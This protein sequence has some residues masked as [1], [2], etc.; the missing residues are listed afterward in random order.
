M[1]CLKDLKLRVVFYNAEFFNYDFS[2]KYALLSVA[3]SQVH[4]GLNKVK[5]SVFSHW[6]VLEAYSLR[7]MGYEKTINE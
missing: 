1:I 5:A 7:A 4:S 3:M 6:L 2:L